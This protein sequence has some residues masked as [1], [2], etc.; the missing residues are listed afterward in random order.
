MWY[1]SLQTSDRHIKRQ[2]SFHRLQNRCRIYCGHSYII[3]WK[4][5]EWKKKL[6]FFKLYHYVSLNSWANL[7]WYIFFLFWKILTVLLI[8]Q[9]NLFSVIKKQ[10]QNQKQTKT[11]QASS[12]TNYVFRIA[13]TPKVRFTENYFLPNIL[14]I[15]S[16]IPT[17]KFD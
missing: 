16:N 2:I 3:F 6:L 9:K 13:A 12:L 5:S 17:Y 15:V 4:F 1:R 7:H 11:L 14:L 10:K 8:T